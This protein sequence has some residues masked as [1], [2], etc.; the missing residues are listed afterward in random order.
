MASES[1]KTVY[2]ALGANAGIAVA[3]FAGGAVSGSSAMLAEAAHSVAD[4]TNQVFLLASLSLAER[5]PDAQHPFGY[6]KERFFWSFMAAVFIFVADALFSFYEGVERIMSGKEDSGGA[7]IPFIV[8][9]V[10]LVLEGTSL[11]RASRQTHAEAERQRRPLARHVRQSRDPTTKTVVFEDSA[12]VIGILLAAAGLA[13]TQITGSATFDGAASIAIGVLLAVVAFALGRDTYGLLIGEAAL[14]EEREAIER[15]I[16]GHSGVD[17]LVELMTM[18]LGPDSI[19][20]AVRLD[21]A[22]ELD[23]DAVEALASDLER[24]IREAVPEVQHVFIDPTHRDERR[25]SVARPT[26]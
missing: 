4:T 10:A 2:I 5:K 21:V 7:V 9:A 3:K 18:A 22:P 6:G 17:E 12:A 11:I 20:V 24:A 15:A 13:L 19:L 8:L 14:P 26:R 23:S 16:C 1:R 25:V